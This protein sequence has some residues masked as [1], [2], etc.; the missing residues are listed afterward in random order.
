MTHEKNS[1]DC[2]FSPLSLPLPSQLVQQ[3]GITH[4]TPTV[5]SF[6]ILPRHVL[7]SC[8][9]SFAIYFLG[10]KVF[11]SRSRER[12]SFSIK[13]AWLPG[14]FSANPNTTYSP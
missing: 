12:V 6:P 3:T 11:W 14:T 9:H 13:P 2:C 7:P 8:W 5:N 10:V 4:W 1:T